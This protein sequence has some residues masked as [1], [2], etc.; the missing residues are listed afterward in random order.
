METATVTVCVLAI[1]T[2]AN[3]LCPLPVSGTQTETTT[4]IERLLEPKPYA[5]SQPP[6]RALGV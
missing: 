6:E 2:M 4:G 5:P 3:Q 1:A